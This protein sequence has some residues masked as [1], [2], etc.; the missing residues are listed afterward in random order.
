[1]N[2]PIYVD[3]AQY[4]QGYIPS[5]T[6]FYLRASISEVTLNQFEFHLKVISNYSIGFNIEFC[7]FLYYPSNYEIIYQ[8]INCLLSSR[9]R[10]IAVNSKNR[11]YIYSFTVN[12]DSQY[13]AIRFIN[14]GPLNYLSFSLNT[15]KGGE[16]EEKKESIELAIIENDIP[17]KKEYQ[18]DE[19]LKNKTLFFLYFENKGEKNYNAKLKIKTIEDIKSNLRIPQINFAFTGL[20]EKPNKDMTIKEIST[21]FSEENIVNLKTINFDD[22]DCGTYEFPFE[23]IYNTKYLG[24][25]FYIDEKLDYLSFYIGPKS[26]EECD[27][28]CDS[29]SIGLIILFTVLYTIVLILIV[30]LVLRK[31]GYTKKDTLS[32]EINQNLEIKLNS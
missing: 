21:K 10:V 15:E 31:L 2:E 14:P 27:D 12:D 23:S 32:S 25:V 18:F 30:Y 28:D 7:S 11:T 20:K 9:S 13:L 24:V 29:I 3:M 16:D 5:N 26:D 1:M 17:Y 4:S 6:Y 19:S 22:D 8:N